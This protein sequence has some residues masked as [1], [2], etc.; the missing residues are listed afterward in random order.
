MTQRPLD[1]SAEPPNGDDLTIK[2]KY[3][4]CECGHSRNLHVEGKACAGLDE[5]E[6]EKLACGCQ[7]FRY[8]KQKP[9]R[10]VPPAPSVPEPAPVDTEEFVSIT[11]IDT[12][13][14]VSITLFILIAVIGVS[15]T[16]NQSAVSPLSTQTE[17]VQRLRRLW[18]TVHEK[19]AH[20]IW[21]VHCW[22]STGH[23]IKPRWRGP[24]RDNC[25]DAEA[26][27]D[28]HMLTFPDHGTNLV[29]PPDVDPSAPPYPCLSQEEKDW[30][31]RAESE[32]EAA[33]P[34]RQKRIDAFVK[35][36][37]EYAA[38]RRRGENDSK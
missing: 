17:A 28:L 15:M 14:F 26:D 27:A 30:R 16:M 11:P 3:A 10:I 13:K 24:D 32:I 19:A 18:N 31:A 37:T 35:H 1:A 12:A 25:W 2:S 7:E 21:Y 20:H 5:L 22:W 4:R 29:Y 8:K 33:D 23:P 34:E 9:N 38:R 6:D 36:L